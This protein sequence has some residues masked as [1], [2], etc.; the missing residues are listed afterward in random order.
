MCE[1]PGGK[2]KK[3][4][5]NKKGEQKD[6]GKWASRTSPPAFRLPIPN[7]KDSMSERDHVRARLREN[8]RGQK[9]ARS[10]GAGISEK[11]TNLRWQNETEVGTKRIACS[12]SVGLTKCSMRTANRRAAKMRRQANKI[13]GSVWVP[14]TVSDSSSDSSSCSE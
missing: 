7:F 13:R 2:K 1:V 8:L 6:N 5:K 3:K 4:K 10:P 9:S 12:T 14:V 11:C